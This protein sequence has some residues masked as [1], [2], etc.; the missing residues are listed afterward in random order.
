MPRHI[1]LCFLR[2]LPEEAFEEDGVVEEEPEKLE[3]ES[4]QPGT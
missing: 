4:F 2:W 3:R 1:T